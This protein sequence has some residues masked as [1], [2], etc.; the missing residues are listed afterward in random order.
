MSKLNLTTQLSSK[1]KEG[2]LTNLEFDLH[3]ALSDAEQAAVEAIGDL[4]VACAS[5]VKLKNEN[6]FLLKQIEELVG[7]EP[8]IGCNNLMT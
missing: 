5:I 7:T 8:D 1:A 6:Q 4:T 2:T 3:Y